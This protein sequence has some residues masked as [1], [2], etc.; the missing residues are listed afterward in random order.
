MNICGRNEKN[1]RAPEVATI[2]KP[3]KVYTVHPDNLLFEFNQLKGSIDIVKKQLRGFERD[4]S[5]D[6]ILKLLSSSMIQF[7]LWVEDIAELE[8]ANKNYVVGVTQS[9]KKFMQDN[10]DKIKK[11][12]SHQMSALNKNIRDD[13]NAANKQRDDMQVVANELRDEM[14]KRKIQVDQIQV[15]V[16]NGQT[17]APALAGILEEVKPKFS[18]Y[19]G[20]MVSIA[21]KLKAL[22]ATKD[23]LR[24]AE[25]SLKYNQN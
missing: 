7:D 1:L 14:N 9:Y 25:K 12:Q 11:F 19:S 6:Q 22:D 23:K 24:F 3:A 13:E 18:S 16:K 15:N 5:A 4:V 2:F 21:Q 10:K 8:R 20:S 17:S